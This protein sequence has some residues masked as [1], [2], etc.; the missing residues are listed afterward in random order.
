MLN[1]IACSYYN[2]IAIDQ[3]GDLYVWGSAQSGLLGN[4]ITKA[5]VIFLGF[6]FDI[7][8]KFPRN[9]TSLR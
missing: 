6:S 9:S 8:R 7:S 1:K 4:G 5:V 3:E 2:T